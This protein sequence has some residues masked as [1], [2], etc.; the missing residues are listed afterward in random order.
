M[1][2]FEA[3]SYGNRISDVYDEMYPSIEPDSI[4][5]LAELAGD[6]PALELGIG[7]GRVALPLRALGLEL[8]GI[9]ASKNMLDVL[10]RKA[11]PDFIY[12]THGNFSS[13]ELGQKYSLIFVVF[14]TIFALTTQEEQLSCFASVG[15]HLK[16]EGHF[17]VEA[18]V[19]DLARFVGNQTIRVV[20]IS[21]GQLQLD[22]SRHDP[23]TQ[24]IIS[25]HILID[26]EGTRL[27]PVKLRY[28]WPSELDLMAKSA[29]LELANR[30]GSW[31]KKIFDSTSHKH[32]SVYHR[33]V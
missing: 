1:G 8:N 29:G 2:E 21:L 12:V 22:A 24:T 13:F 32:I 15:R 4:N 20:D 11:K 30:W 28:I 9:E 10:K 19:P 26:E 33:P 5:L 17:L 7:T 27:Y 18:F 14:N 25:Q 23:A 31:Q 6:G 16:P 3:S